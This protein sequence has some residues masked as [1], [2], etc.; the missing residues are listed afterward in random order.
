MVDHLPVA[1]VFSSVVWHKVASAW[2]VGIQPPGQMDYLLTWCTSNVLGTPNK[3]DL[4]AIMG[5]TMWE[6]WKHRNAVVFDNAWP[7]EQRFYSGSRRK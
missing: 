4:L 6:L 1:C 7:E 5:L 2:G 3:R